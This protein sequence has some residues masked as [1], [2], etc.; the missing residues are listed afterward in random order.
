VSRAREALGRVEL[1]IADDS[2][3]EAEP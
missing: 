1:V 3:K 2:I